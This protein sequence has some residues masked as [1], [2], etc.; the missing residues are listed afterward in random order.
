MEIFTKYSLW[1]ILPIIIASAGLSFYLYYKDKKLEKISKIVLYILFF[2]RFSVLSILG[3]LLLMPIVKHYSIFLDK[4]LIIIAQDNSESI[5]LT[6]SID[7]CKPN[8]YKNN[9]LNLYN[10]LSEKYKVKFYTFGDR[11]NDSLN[12]QFNAKET[13][14][15]SIF[16]LID[17]KYSNYNIGALVIASDGI[18][19]KGSNP[20]H[21]AKKFTFP[22]YTVA[23]G[24]T[25]QKRDL[26]L[27]SVNA[28]RIAFLNDIFPVE[29]IFN[30]F[31]YAGQSAKIKIIHKGKTL[32][33]KTVKIDN[34]DFARQLDFEI[35]ASEKSLQRYTVAVDIKQDE[36][37]KKNN[38]KQFVVDVLDDKKKILILYNSVHPDIGAIKNAIKTNKNIQVESISF[39]K[40]NINKSTDYQM[41]ILHQLPSPTHNI[42]QFS[43][44]ISDKKIPILYIFGNHTD[45]NKFNALNTGISIK[46]DKK[47]RELALPE[48]NHGFQLFEND[49]KFADLISECAPLN[50]FFGT[51]NIG[52]E[53]EILLKQNIK[54][55]STN[56]PLLAFSNT[57][58][59]QGAKQAVLFGEGIWRWRIK[60]YM[61]NENH[62]QFD[63]FINR[64]VQFL[65]LDIKKER[66]M[67]YNKNIA[68]ENEELIIRAE[69]YNQ[70]YELYNKADVFLELKNE[71]NKLYKFSFSKSGMAYSINIGKLPKGNYT[72]TAY[73]IFEGKKYKKTGQISIIP[74]NIEEQN[75]KANHLLLRQLSEQSGGK[76]YYPKQYQQLA[77]DLKS[78][79]SIKAASHSTIDLVDLIQIEWI[80]LL[81]IIFLSVEWFV[82]KFLGA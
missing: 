77:N 53:F 73:T 70:S 68:Y 62:E 43:K 76:L 72:F 42:K 78:N 35:N 67:V 54:G 55:V 27:R 63:A 15:T 50:T 36:F 69:L 38:S 32:D 48:I 7:N 9:I 18:Y 3:F 1:F 40:F 61:L 24:D 19:N 30:A 74:L 2:L 12:Y 34:N 6:N 80:L 51:Y 41:I 65:A 64:I 17:K 46:A 10:D 45:I 25:S 82:R 60:D 22:V 26:I 44:K 39:D 31:G 11:I 14:F 71:N 33:S 5:G 47:I 81:L 56:K 13:D 29:I 75:F 57:L 49:N 23:L 37:S 8:D 16:N 66:F 59:S 4:P 21:I 52:K 79:K 20:V 28:N 58:Y